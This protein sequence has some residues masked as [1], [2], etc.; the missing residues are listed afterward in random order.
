MSSAAP[1]I[2]GR[3]LSA[4]NR[5]KDR[6]S[7]LYGALF[8][9]TED[10]WLVHEASKPEAILT[11]A[12][13]SPRAWEYWETYYADH[14]PAVRLWLYSWKFAKPKGVEN[15]VPRDGMETFRDHSHVAAVADA[16]IRSEEQ[17][18]TSWQPDYAGHV[19]K[20]LVWSW[21]KKHRDLEWFD[22]W[23]TRGED[24]PAGIT[25]A[26][27]DQV[28]RCG[29]AWDF[30]G[31]CGR[32]GLTADGTYT[33]WIKAKRIPDPDWLKWLY[34]APAPESS[35]VVGPALQRLRIE[36]SLSSIRRASKVS[37]TA[38]EHWKK[39]PH[40][41]ARLDEAIAAGHRAHRKPA[42]SAWS[43]EWN[44]LPRRTRS[45]MLGFARARSA[46]ECCERAEVTRS[47]ADN[48]LVEARQ[49]GVEKDLREFLGLDGKYHE[50]PQRG[51][52]RPNF[53]IPSEA[54]LA[55]RKV[56]L[57]EWTVQRIA[58]LKS[59]PAFEEWFLDW[60]RPGAMDGRR[61]SLSAMR[62]QTASA[63][64]ASGSVAKSKGGRPMSDL[65]QEVYKFC[66][67]HFIT[68]SEKRAAVRSA[69]EKKFGERAPKTKADVRKYAI[70][71][72]N[73]HTLSTRRIA[74]TP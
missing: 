30:I 41:K 13:L 29:K 27:A 6:G 62:R 55:F 5:S 53:F 7:A 40:L 70:R 11:R 20:Q 72:A 73:R 59:L 21:Q 38:L 18:R 31:L 71:Y 54:M 15:F 44:A 25:I 2:H 34:G 26:T 43:D 66:Y 4:S 23:L 45:L 67:D 8:V 48:L 33:K 12:G 60:A 49:R 37:M 39:T 58:E 56:A 46:G 14:W 3:K 64:P 24:A 9:P 36:R 19:T 10:M 61:P 16:S 74:K 51:L 35:F 1:S 32:A 65:T 68:A 50:F 57:E 69:A 63:V 42:G 52:V 28:R 47:H 22:P 17:R